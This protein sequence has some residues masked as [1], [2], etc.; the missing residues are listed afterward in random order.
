[1]PT[2]QHSRVES[3]PTSLAES[4]VLITHVSHLSVGLQWSGVTVAILRS[5]IN[6]DRLNILDKDRQAIYDASR[7]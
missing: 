1:M 3:S 5:E 6:V 7:C 2:H 4:R